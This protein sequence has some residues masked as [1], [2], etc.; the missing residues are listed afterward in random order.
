MKKSLLSAV[1]SFALSLTLMGMSNESQAHGPT[2]QKVTQS[3]D[4]AAPPA[5]VWDAI[6]DFSGLHT[7]HPAIESS[8][9]TAGNELGSVRTLTL[10]GGGKVVEVLKKYDAAG[11]SYK[12][13]MTDPGP[14]PVNNY[15]STIS[16]AAKG[17]GSVVTWKGAFYRGYPNNDPPPELNDEAAVK[18][19][20]GIYQS[21]LANLKKMIEGK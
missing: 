18:A 3:V 2:R 4:I 15:T 5:K 13:R 12:Y 19:V 1:L 7:W 14:V 10:G 11:M 9:T 17:E 6:K 21:G 16:V 20:T 8:E